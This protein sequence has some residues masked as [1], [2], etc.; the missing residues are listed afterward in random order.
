MS[1]PNAGGAV[2][3]PQASPYKAYSGLNFV[4]HNRRSSLA[5]LPI[6]EKEGPT[7]SALAQ[8]TMS[9]QQL[10]SPLGKPAS[11]S[12]T[13]SSFSSG[14]TSSSLATSVDS[15]DMSSAA[16]TVTG[17]EQRLVETPPVIL[18]DT[19][20]PSDLDTL[21]TT[22]STNSNSFLNAK[23]STPSPAAST[24]ASPALE[25]L[26]PTI[27]LPPEVEEPPIP[28]TS[29]ARAMEDLS[30][31]K[32]SSPDV[33]PSR[34]TTSRSSSYA[35]L[36]SSSSSLKR[37][38]YPR[39]SIGSVVQAKRRLVSAPFNKPP[40][41]GSIAD[42]EVPQ[43]RPEAPRRTRSRHATRATDAPLDGQTPLHLS[44]SSL[45]RL[46]TEMVAES[47]A[48]GLRADSELARWSLDAGKSYDGLSNLVL[49][50]TTEEW[51]QLGGDIGRS[52]MKLMRLNSS[53]SLNASSGSR[54]L[55]EDTRYNSDE[56]ED[57]SSSS[58]GSDE[59][60]DYEQVARPDAAP[61]NS[62]TSLKVVGKSQAP[63]SQQS[64]L[65]HQVILPSDE[66]PVL[67]DF[68]ED[69]VP[70]R[71]LN[72]HRDSMSRTAASGLVGL[73]RYNSS[74]ATDTSSL[75]QSAISASPVALDFHGPVDPR[76]Y[77]A[78]TGARTIADF[79]IESEAGKGA[80][81]TVVRGHA[82][83]ANGQPEGV[84]LPLLSE[85]ALKLF[86]ATAHYQVHHQA[87]NPGRLLEEAQ[88]S[89]SHPSRNPRP[90]SSPTHTL[91]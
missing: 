90:R 81:G 28:S 77:S 63:T 91:H 85:T 14:R 12:S 5:D 84:S 17:E 21:H 41:E 29:K 54:T 22:K 89:R 73:R 86:A 40:R 67:N 27:S 11:R 26:S 68:E 70:P 49:T 66:E 74:F 78:R 76:S 65:K 3:A 53:R 23:P 31:A 57:S 51:K 48:E 56:N 88:N 55:G 50:P 52:R 35:D 61:W 62:S 59:D 36:A 72:Q 20:R 71:S 24:S 45:A 6:K 10:E 39:Q 33:S 82:K 47:Q 16:S 69:K 32:P 46:D 7:S 34:M 79:V 2:F 60:E 18:Q 30:V 9:D 25:P 37:Q 8:R 58:S 15:Y 80:Y 38:H 43:P 13:D 4:S 44:F 1:S 64:D 19:R 42:V 75:L 87:T 83:D